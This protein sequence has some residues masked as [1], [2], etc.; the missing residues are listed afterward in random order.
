MLSDLMTE[1]YKAL[2]QRRLGITAIGA[3]TARGMG[4]KGT[5][6]AVRLF[7]GKLDLRAFEAA[8]S[9]VEFAKAL[10]LATEALRL[11]MPF[12][13]RNWGSARKFMNIFLRD[14]CYNRHM[15]E[16]YRLAEVEQWLEVP[17]DSLVAQ[18]L[19]NHDAQNDLPRWK[20]VIGLTSE[21]S[22]C[23]QSFATRFA[24]E[25]HVYRVHLDL[26]FWRTKIT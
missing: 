4:P 9:H 2:L 3:S 26:L 16:F 19:R 15:C 1:H 12:E 6:E 7:L 21:Q 23:F 17:L 8:N 18:G 25:K 11:T 20:T 10:N 24:A 5:I 13:A 22:E 14:C